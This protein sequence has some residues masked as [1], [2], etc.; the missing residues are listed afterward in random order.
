MPAIRTAGLRPAFPNISLRQGYAL[1]RWK[2]STGFFQGLENK[3]MPDHPASKHWKKYGSFD[4][5]R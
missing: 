1:T 2:L 4:A 3:C 5:K